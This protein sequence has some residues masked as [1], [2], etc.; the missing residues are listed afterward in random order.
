D[1]NR[2]FPDGRPA[3]EPDPDEEPPSALE[4]AYTRLFDEIRATAGLYVD[5]HN[6]WTGS[7]SF[8]YRDRVFYRNEGSAAERK[9]ARGEAQKVDQ[10]LGEMCAAYGHPIVNEL[11]VKKYLANKLH[12]STT[13]AAVN[14][15][16]I[17]A[18]T[19]ELG[20]GHLPDPAIVS[21]AGAGLRN[22]M[23]W[24]GMLPGDPEPIAGIRL[25][26][27]GFAC[28]RRMAPYTSQ[29]CVIHHLCEPGDL[30]EKGQAIAEVRDIYGRPVGEKVLYSEYDGWV[31]ARSH[32]V[33]YYP[34]QE[35]YGLAIRDDLPT[36]Q[37]YP[38][39]YFK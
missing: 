2:L 20:T 28:R 5:L 18:L 32:G 25:P 29:A 30:I 4:M 13:A 33:I 15:A 23:R 1:P 36:V 37:A 7:V 10:Q 14:L 19:M 21:A 38:K 6:A 27:P 9:R 34:G 31:I 24:A 39:D 12:R 22:V 35:V 11:P 17:P 16:H 3:G 8:A 26:N